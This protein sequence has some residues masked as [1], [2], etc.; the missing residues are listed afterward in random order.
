MDVRVGPWRK[1]AEQQS[2]H[3]TKIMAYGP[4]TSLQIDRETM[5]TVLG[6]K[7]SVDGDCSHEINR[8]LLLGINIMTN[9]NS[10]LK[11]RDITLSTKVHLV[12]AKVF[13]VVVYWCESWTI[14]KSEC[15]RIDTFELWCGKDSESPLDWKV[16]KPV[17]S[18]GNQSWIFIER[19]DAEA[20]A[21]ILW[22]PNVKN[23]LTG[24]YPDAGKDWRQTEKGMTEDDV[25]GCHHRLHGSMFEQVPE[26][27]MDSKAWHAA[28]QGVTKNQTWLSHWTEVTLTFNRSTKAS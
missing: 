23:W 9:L 3:T 10:I 7:I 8:R 19:T 15:W 25:V 18:K 17:N 14:N 26:F 13:L 20:E 11:S 16:I 22:P 4:I 1:L 24:E 21:L 5:E 12:K 2:I 28:V 6:S 27:F